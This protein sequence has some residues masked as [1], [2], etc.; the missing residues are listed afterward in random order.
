MRA[1]FRFERY[2]RKRWVTWMRNLTAA[3]D[4]DDCAY[5]YLIPLCRTA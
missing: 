2:S 5:R 4:L 1:G 3:D